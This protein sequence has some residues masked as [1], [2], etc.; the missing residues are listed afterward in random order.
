MIEAEGKEKQHT[1]GKQYSSKLTAVLEGSTNGGSVNQGLRSTSALHVD[2]GILTWNCS[3]HCTAGEPGT[4][5]VNTAINKAEPITLGV[6]MQVYSINAVR[7]L[8]FM[9][10]TLKTGST[11]CLCH[12]LRSFCKMT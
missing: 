7:V 5:T 2:S 12:L 3:V 4:V 11:E 8:H 9:D 6:S 10:N 1:E